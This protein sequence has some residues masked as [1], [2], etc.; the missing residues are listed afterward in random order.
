[1]TERHLNIDV[2]TAADSLS[3]KVWRKAS[4]AA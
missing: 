1:M 3:A 2:S 4:G